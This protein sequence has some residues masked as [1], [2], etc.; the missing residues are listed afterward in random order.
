VSRRLIGA[1]T[2]N[3][4]FVE[5]KLPI[6]QIRPLIGVAYPTTVATGVVLP[7]DLVRPRTSLVDTSTAAVLFQ[8]VSGWFIMVEQIPSIYMFFEDVNCISNL[9][10]SSCY[11]SL[12]SCPAMC[13]LFIFLDLEFF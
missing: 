11:V 5:N 8:Q 4:A 7:E 12:L 6:C 3:A 9:Y 2:A 1:H 10:S 13:Q